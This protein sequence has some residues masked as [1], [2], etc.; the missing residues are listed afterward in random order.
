MCAVA[1]VRSRRL[2]AV[3]IFGAT[4]GLTACQDGTSPSDRITGASKAIVSQPGARRHM[5]TIHDEFASLARTSPGFAGLFLSLDGT[6]TIVV[7]GGPAQIAA[8][9]S[10]AW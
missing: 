6:P 2:I 9:R 7:A 5:H 10:A 4:A 1:G 8:A 3:T